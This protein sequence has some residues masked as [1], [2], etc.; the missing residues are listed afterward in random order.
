MLNYNWNRPDNVLELDIGLACCPKPKEAVLSS[1]WN[2]V[3]PALVKLLNS[4]Q[5]IHVL[6]N[7]KDSSHKAFVSIKG[8]E[9]LQLEVDEYGHLWHVLANGTFTVTVSV[10]GFVPMTK[11]VR[12]MTAEF[13]EVNFNLPYSPGLP[14]AI[15]V[16][17]LS[18]VVL[19][20]L[21]C[22]LLVH[23]RQEKKKT[24]RSYEGFQLLRYYI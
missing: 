1:V 7:N 6:V 8:F 15:Y 10:E 19:C 16:V 22:S 3:R 9:G 13:T 4:L 14:K 12:V 20:I 2:R 18:T 24:V 23:C 21:L 5:G 17:L 11:L